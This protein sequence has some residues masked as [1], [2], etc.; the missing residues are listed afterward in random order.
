LGMAVRYGAVRSFEVREDDAL[1]GVGCF[2]NAILSRGP[3]DASRVVALAAAPSDAFVE[4]PGAD[5]PAAGIRY[6]DAPLTI[7][8][9]RCLLLADLGGLTVG[10]AHFSHIGSGERRLQTSAT[11]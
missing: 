3:I 5:H 11:L 2:G 10:T 6:A 8:E 9:P 4:P 1:L 7:R